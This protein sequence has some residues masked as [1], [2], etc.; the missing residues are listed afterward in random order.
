VACQGTLTA[1]RS[2]DDLVA[3]LASANMEP[4]RDKPFHEPLDGWRYRGSNVCRNNRFTGGW[5]GYRAPRV[6]YKGLRLHWPK[7][8]SSARPKDP[9]TLRVS[10]TARCMIIL[11]CCVGQR[12]QQHTWRQRLQQRTRRQGLQHRPGRQR[13][14]HL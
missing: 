3:E 7:R 4:M 13:L 10:R 2:F 9:G 14:Q 12:L 5:L 6:E 1:G 11:A 8:T